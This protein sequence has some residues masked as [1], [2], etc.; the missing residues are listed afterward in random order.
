MSKYG[1]LDLWKHWIRSWL[2]AWRQQV[3]NGT[4]VDQSSASSCST[5]MRVISLYIY[6]LGRSLTITNWGRVTH[7]W[8][9]ISVQIMVCQS[10]GQ[11][12][13]IIWTNAGLLL[14]GSLVTNFSEILIEIP[15]SLK[16]MRLEAS[17]AKWRPFCP[18]VLRLQLHRPGVSD[19]L[20]EKCYQG[21]VCWWS[22]F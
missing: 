3:F 8:V 7:I 1:D 4:N 9:V 12:Q 2:L 13:T 18:N 21:N 6:I 5:Y 16:T 11:R 22:K 15:F 19:E 10:P 17:S 20:P 14:N